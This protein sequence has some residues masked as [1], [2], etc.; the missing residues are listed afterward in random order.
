MLSWRRLGVLLRQLPH[1]S[2]THTALRD[3]QPHWSV[4]AHLMAGM[5][6]VLQWANYQR[7]GKGRKPRPIERPGDERT[8]RI[9]RRGLSVE[10][11]E[12]RL[13]YLDENAVEAEPEVIL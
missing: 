9:G 12:E 6:D 13:K 5:F 2:R 3:D 8:Q 7:A 10:Q 11:L 1:D 4:E